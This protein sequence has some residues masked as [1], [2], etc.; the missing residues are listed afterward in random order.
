MKNYNSEKDNGII[1]SHLS[2]EAGY[3]LSWGSILAGVITFLAIFLLFSLI[4]SAIGLGGFDPTSRN[5]VT[6][7]G[8]GMAIWTVISL[9][10]SLF[11]GGFVAGLA[12]RRTGLLHGFLTWALSVILVF[13]LVTSTALGAIS[14]IG[15]AI[16]S[17][18]GAVTSNQTKVVVEGEGQSNDIISNI[19]NK[20]DELNTEAL[21]EETQAILRDTEVDE[22][23]PEYLNQELK[24]VKDEILTAGKA[25]VLEP[26]NTDIIIS[27]LVYDLQ[28]R[29]DH[30]S[31]N[32]DRDAI[33]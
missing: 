29:I 2:K 1:S 15:K 25:I 5:P 19:G 24:E 11:A 3:N 28:N 27:D 26:Q 9:L 7:V 31:E 33:K 17:I 22:L 16:G 23:Q 14:S 18:S 13:W 21:S 10:I 12:A 20:I 4:T 32:I 6:G 30:I 8:T